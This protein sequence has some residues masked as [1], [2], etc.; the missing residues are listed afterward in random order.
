MAADKR[1]R[2]E[3]EATEKAEWERAMAREW[4]AYKSSRHMEHHNSHSHKHLED[5]N[6]LEHHN[7]HS[8]KH[9]KNDHHLENHLMQGS[10]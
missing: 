4:S 5:D 8:H 9:L 1:L 6:L 3:Q 10:A 2:K 7:S